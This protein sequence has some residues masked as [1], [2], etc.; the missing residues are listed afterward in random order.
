[1]QLFL[2]L[3]LSSFYDVNATELRRFF[4]YELQ[5]SVSAARS[6]DEFGMY[7]LSGMHEGPASYSLGMGGSMSMGMGRGGRG[8]RRMRSSA[9]DLPSLLLDSRIIFLGMPV[10]DQFPTLFHYWYCIRFGSTYFVVILADC[11]GSN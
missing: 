1:M 9:P 10:R 11:S 5:E 7:T 8:Y 6:Y 4:A 2:F 3:L